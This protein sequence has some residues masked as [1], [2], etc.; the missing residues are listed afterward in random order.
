MGTEPGI[1]FNLDAESKY[2]GIDVKPDG[3]LSKSKENSY[4]KVWGTVGS[5]ARADVDL[6]TRYGNI[7][8]K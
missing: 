5:G 1:A 7:N 3:N 8:I 6:V 2:G 4:M